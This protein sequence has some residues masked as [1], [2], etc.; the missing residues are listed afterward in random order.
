M[1]KEWIE[2]KLEKT[3][4]IMFKRHPSDLNLT[5]VTHFKNRKHG[6]MLKCDQ[7][8]VYVENDDVSNIISDCDDWIV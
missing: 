7:G 6:F 3:R 1:S 2:I 4:K 5:N 8:V